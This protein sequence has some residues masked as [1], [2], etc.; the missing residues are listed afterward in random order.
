[1]PEKLFIESLYAA[2]AKNDSNS[3]DLARGLNILSKTVFGDVNRFIFELLQNAD[4]SADKKNS[5]EL[6][7]EFRLVENYL[8]FSHTGIHFSEEDVR[9][10]SRLGGG[11]SNKDKDIE[12]TG[13]KGIGFKSVF[14]SSDY[15]HIISDKFSFR[16]DRNHQ[17]WA[18]QNDYP[19]QL[20]PIW[21]ENLSD[22][23]S[24]FIE[25]QKVNTIIKIEEREKIRQEIENVFLDCQIVLFLRNIK[26]IKFLVGAEQIFEIEKR[27]TETGVRGLYKNNTLLSNWIIKDYFIEVTKSLRDKISKLSDYECPQKLKVAELTKITFAAMINGNQILPVKDGLIYCYLPT[28]VNKNLPYLVNGDFITNAERTQFLQN[29]WNDFLFENIA[30]KQFEWIKELLLTDFKFQTTKLIKNTYTSFYNQPKIE[31]QF[32][33]GFKTAIDSIDFLPETN[34]NITLKVNNSVIDTTGYIELYPTSVIASFLKT[35]SKFLDRRL[36]SPDTIIDIG[37]KEFGIGDLCSFFHSDQFKTNGGLTFELNIKTIE[38]LFNSTNNGKNNSWIELLKQTNFLLDESNRLTTPKDIYLPLLD[39]QKETSEFITLDLLHKVVYEYFKNNIPIIKWFNDL[40]VKEPTPIEVVRKSVFDIIRDNKITDANCLQIT[41]FVFK[42]FI[43]GQLNENDYSVLSSI[44]IITSNGLNYPSDS[45]LANEYNPQ[46]KLINI[47]PTANFVSTNY[48][49]DVEYLD[50]WKDF[51]LKMGVKENITVVIYKDKTERLSFIDNHPKTKSY[52]NWLD[53]GKYQSVYVP[54]SIYGQHGI[55]NFTTIN[56]IEYLANH[57]L[58]KMFWQTAINNWDIFHSNC[59][60]T[61]YYHKGGSEYVPS[62]IEFYVKENNCF[63]A[64]DGVCYT[65]SELYIPD[66]KTLIGNHF[67]VA[68]LEGYIKKEQI[69]FFGFKRKITF[70]DCFIILDSLVGKS[71]DASVKKQI[72]ALYEQIIKSSSDITLDDSRIINEWKTDGKLLA[73][74]NSFQGVTELYCFGVEGCDP[75]VNSEKFVSL[76]EDL[77]FKEINSFASMFNLPVVT[78]DVLTFVP[79]NPKKELELYETLSSIT[80]YLSVIIAQKNSDTQE[81]VFNKIFKIIS[82]TT[83]YSS[84]NLSLVYKAKDQVEIF[85]SNIESWNDDVNKKFYYIGKWNSPLTLYSLSDSLCR[86]IDAVG[87]ERELALFLQ[88]SEDEIQSWLLEKGHEISDIVSIPKNK[89]EVKLEDKNN[90]EISLEIQEIFN[91]EIKASE[92]DFSNMQVAKRTTERTE[93][94]TAE[95]N[96]VIQPQVKIDIG[97]WSEECVNEYLMKKVGSSTIIIWENKDEESFK[98][99]D[100]KIIE[101]GVTK[102]IEVKGTP[103][104]KTEL[105]ITENEWD[106]MFENGASYSIYRLFNAGKKDARIEFID[107]PSSLI[108]QGSFLKFPVSLFV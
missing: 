71:I 85:N 36:T 54:F 63:P 52:F 5:K 105:F 56:F 13:Y 53:K 39:I 83:F 62:Y 72:V 77:T 27:E 81:N 51:F 80:K 48:V 26:S 45:Y 93:I 31:L 46:L 100:F 3:S 4:D 34:S 47:V 16:F 38:F 28:D 7:V 91:P 95:N 64:T 2:K 22:E 14:G 90:E 30:I 21:T 44:K 59:V 40:G 12:K 55:S 19:W 101:N 103:F 43:S 25:K 17:L 67:P 49:E 15:V 60:A 9:G 75:P 1:M 58:S 104:G 41:R 69:E 35:S 96:E 50:K 29:D 87:S 11:D 61:R 57:S 8:V 97:R 32:N 33:K 74:N 102:Y 88:L 78:S 107:N 18:G 24:P 89:V 65:S 6:N 68:D 79:E 20:I 84:K 70:S 99:Y 106:F 76:P 92:V 10:I 73:I 94:T 86:F 108:S 42:V 37:V 66:L 98:S 23:V 82:S